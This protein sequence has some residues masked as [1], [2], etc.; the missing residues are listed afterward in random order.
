MIN[1][2]E[3]DEDF[4]KHFGTEFTFTGPVICIDD[5]DFEDYIG[6]EHVSYLGL[7]LQKDEEDGK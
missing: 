6:K 2:K 5:E 3:S 7:S 1:K 4:I